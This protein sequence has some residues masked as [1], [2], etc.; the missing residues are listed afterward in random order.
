M[1]QTRTKTGT[2]R[3]LTSK[4]IDGA[5]NSKRKKT[6]RVK[7]DAPQWA[8]RFAT[9]MGHVLGVDA[10]QDSKEK[11][12]GMAIK[13]WKVLHIMNFIYPYIKIEAETESTRRSSTAVADDEDEIIQDLGHLSE[14]V[15]AFEKDKK[16]DV[17]IVKSRWKEWLARCENLYRTKT[18]ERFERL[19]ENIAESEQDMAKCV[20]ATEVLAMQAKWLE[21]ISEY[22]L[23]RS[24][25]CAKDQPAK[26]EATY[27]AS[28]DIRTTI[29]EKSPEKT[30]NIIPEWIVRWATVLGYAIGLELKR[31][32]RGKK[33][34]LETEDNEMIT[35]ILNYLL[36]VITA[37]REA[38]S[39]SASDSQ[40]DEQEPIENSDAD[41]Y[42]LLLSSVKTFAAGFEEDRAR[43]FHD[44]ESVMRDWAAECRQAYGKG[45]Q[46]S[47]E[48]VLRQ[49]AKEEQAMKVKKDE[50]ARMQARWKARFESHM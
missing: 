10:E 42:D 50:L 27:H 18:K 16:R 46:Q 3:P 15:E 32:N 6:E 38:E 39:P 13:D 20:T 30:L 22:L 11:K 1:Y 45:P 14:F 40:I 2:K 48:R 28:N 47:L 41:E 23:T 25:T 34:Q 7:S 9:I 21:R 12:G 49:I 33:L 19:F 8:V 24:K 29:Q 26:V 4:F 44:H 43:G 35:Y 17:N 36:P 31:D 37:I 5:T